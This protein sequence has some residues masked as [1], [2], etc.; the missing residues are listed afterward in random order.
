LIEWQEEQKQAD[1]AK[2]KEE[3]MRENQAEQEKAREEE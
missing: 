2:A 3:Q 1:I